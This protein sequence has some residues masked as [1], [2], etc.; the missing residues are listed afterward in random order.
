MSEMLLEGPSSSWGGGLAETQAGM[1][2]AALA[3]GLVHARHSPGVIISLSRQH[4]ANIQ[5]QVTSSGR[6][7]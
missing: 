5:A 1:M 6:G 4:P 2:L 3:K 7:P